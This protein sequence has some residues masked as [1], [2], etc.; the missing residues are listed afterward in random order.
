MGRVLD[1][2]AA[3][4]RRGSHLPDDRL[5]QV[6][7]RQCYGPH[8]A[9]LATLGERHAVSGG[10]K[11]LHHDDAAIVETLPLDVLDLAKAVRLIQRNQVGRP[12]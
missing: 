11:F 9:A 4:V 3:R 2:V 7:A 8:P 10:E 5:V 1:S 6:A 12:L